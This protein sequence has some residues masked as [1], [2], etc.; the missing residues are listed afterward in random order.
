MSYG[1][2]APV[3][4]N[5]YAVPAY[6][7]YPHP[8]AGW[9]QGPPVQ[10]DSEGQELRTLFITG[11]PPDVKERE[12]NNTMR[13]LPGY[14][15]SQ[16][17]R[18]A[19]QTCSPPTPKSPLP[20]GVCMPPPHTHRTGRVARLRALLSSLRAH[21]RWQPAMWCPLYNL[22]RQPSCGVKWPGRTCM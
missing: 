13:F 10:Y 9:P 8:P 22:M 3:S 14:L 5:P 15:A 16:M 6:P 7:A 12:L 1:Y 18:D 17:V 19:I 2:A 4:Y 20:N 21:T 11:F